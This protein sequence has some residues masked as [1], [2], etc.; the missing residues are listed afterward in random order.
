MLQEIDYLKALLS[1]HENS[2][3]VDEYAHEF[4]PH[5]VSEETMKK[6]ASIANSLLA[7]SLLAFNA[8]PEKQIKLSEMIAIHVQALYMLGKRSGT[9][10]FAVSDSEQ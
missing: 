1:I 8:E 6:M 4:D 7:S 5:S 3:V 10:T 2:K 9:V